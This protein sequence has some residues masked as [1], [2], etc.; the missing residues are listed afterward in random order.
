[1]SFMFTPGCGCAKPCRTCS[2]LLADG[3]LMPSV[4]RGNID[5]VLAQVKTQRGASC[6]YGRLYVWSID[7]DGLF[8]GQYPE[9]S[10]FD[11]YTTYFDKTTGQ[12]RCDENGDVDTGARNL[13]SFITS[14]QDLGHVVYGAWR[15]CEYPHCS[16]SSSYAQSLSVNASLVSGGAFNPRSVSWRGH[17]I[18]RLEGESD[19][20]WITR[21]VDSYGTGV[22]VTL[23]MGPLVV[24]YNVTAQLADWTE[25]SAVWDIFC[26]DFFMTCYNVRGYLQGKIIV[27]QVEDN[28]IRKRAVPINVSEREEQFVYTHTSSDHSF[29]MWEVGGTYSGALN[30]YNQLVL[31][32]FYIINNYIP[33]LHD[34]RDRVFYEW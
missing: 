1:M 4:G 27:W 20:E 15:K 2:S 26:R 8:H 24:Q 11:E 34:T 23:P 5:T 16:S 12:T 22:Y 31:Q 33:P 9:S 18:D 17:L 19:E 3:L 28:F 10:L 7:G 25:E 32:R 13:R 14:R 29:Y 30:K 6:Q 21:A